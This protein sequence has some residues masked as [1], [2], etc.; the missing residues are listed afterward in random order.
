MNNS[1]DALAAL[2]RRPA[3]QYMD[4]DGAD[5]VA[6]NLLRPYVSRMR[7]RDL[8]QLEEALG[9]AAKQDALRALLARR[10]AEHT[11][12][13]RDVLSVLASAVAIAVFLS[14]RVGQISRRTELR[15]EVQQ[16][17]EQMRQEVLERQ[18][19]LDSQDV[20]LS[21]PTATQEEKQALQAVAQANRT[22]I[23]DYL[24]QAFGAEFTL[25]EDPSFVPGHTDTVMAIAT[26]PAGA[27]YA[28]MADVDE[29]CRIIAIRSAVEVDEKEN[30]VEID[31][32]QAS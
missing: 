21:V 32:E 29:E 17:M 13:R 9:S 19:L 28:V 12:H 30:K 7:R 1:G 16:S 4:V 31:D 15:Q 23:L 22:A 10:R 6:A 11:K 26:D 5:Q 20:S 18:D 14:L 3:A 25:E 2:R 8:D 27:R 24:R